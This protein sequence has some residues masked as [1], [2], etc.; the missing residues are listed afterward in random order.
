MK[1]LFVAIA[2]SAILA[3]GGLLIG[4]GISPILLAKLSCDSDSCTGGSGFG[5][6]GAGGRFTI[7]ED[8]TFTQSGGGGSK[9][10][11]GGG[12]G[13]TVCDPS[14]ECERVGGSSD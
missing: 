5:G 14:G 7:D 3:V 1:K 2:I 13:R 12:G 6:G 11:P 9:F 10:L 8:G 4:S